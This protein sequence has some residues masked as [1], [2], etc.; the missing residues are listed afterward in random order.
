MQYF[1]TDL[2]VS[3]EFENFFSTIIPAHYFTF[4]LVT[5]RSIAVH[6]ARNHFLDTLMVLQLRA[7]E[8]FCFKQLKALTKAIHYLQNER[9]KEA[10][11]V[12][13]TVNQSFLADDGWGDKKPF[14]RGLLLSDQDLLNNP[15]NSDRNWFVPKP[16]ASRKMREAREK[17]EFMKLENDAQKARAAIEAAANIRH[18]H[19]RRKGDKYAWYKD[20]PTTY[21]GS[22]KEFSDKVE[23]KKDI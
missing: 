23:Y 2:S 8:H 1:H 7:K 10:K 12:P 20:M 11:S 22:Y 6:G 15:N 21:S 18:G 5:L 3:I 9:T 16:N 14:Q 13:K 4:Y 19:I 17:A